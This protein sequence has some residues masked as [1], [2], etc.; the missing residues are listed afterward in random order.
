MRIPSYIS[1][2]DQDPDF[3]SILAEQLHAIISECG[4][5]R[6]VDVDQRPEERSSLGAMFSLDA[7]AVAELKTEEWDDRP[8]IEKIFHVMIESSIKASKQAPEPQTNRMLTHIPGTCTIAIMLAISFTPVVDGEE[9]DLTK[10]GRWSVAMRDPA[11]KVTKNWQGDVLDKQEL[12]DALDGV[13]EACS[14]YRDQYKLKPIPGYM[15]GYVNA[16]AYGNGPGFGGPLGGLNAAAELL[17]GL[18]VGGGDL[19]AGDIGVGQFV[20]EPPLDTE[21]PQG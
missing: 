20:P 2:P 12:Q 15:D 6:A 8:A 10:V 14:R 16:P 13:R 9:M 11:L 18:G 1:Q 3:L 19:K 21:G 4:L 7:D 5:K 17:R